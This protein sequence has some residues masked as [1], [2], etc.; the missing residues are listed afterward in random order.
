MVRRGWEAP[1]LAVAR[2]PRA[3]APTLYAAVAAP[4]AGHRR[5]R[6]PAGPPNRCALRWEPAPPARLVPHLVD[7]C[8][9]L[10][11]F[12][13]AGLRPH[14]AGRPRR[15]AACSARP[16][17]RPPADASAWPQHVA[18]DA[19]RRR[20]AVTCKTTWALKAAMLQE[21]SDSMPM[22]HDSSLTSEN[23][24]TLLTVGTRSVTVT[25]TVTGWKT[26]VFPGFPCGLPAVF[27]VYG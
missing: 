7:A 23:L 24:G 27:P 5:L 16:T 12:G 25:V 20:S 9:P 21:T 6:P 26:V 4:I 22:L 18:L 8:A 1:L 11:P 14:Q 2:L 10:S 3:G 15:A 13:G 19:R 17:W